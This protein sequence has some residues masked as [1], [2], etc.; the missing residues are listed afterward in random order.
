LRSTWGVADNE[1]LIGMVARFNPGKDHTNLLDAL[2]QLAI[3][4]LA[5]RCVLVGDGVSYDNASLRSFIESR[6]L[7]DQLLLLPPTL[8]I[9]EMMAALDIHVLS[10]SGEAFPNVLAEAM[11]CGTPCVSTDV[12]DAA[13]I[14]GE[15]GWIVPPRNSAALADALE[16]AVQSLPDRQRWLARQGAARQRISQNF[17]LERM[18]DSYRRLW[19][20][21]RNRSDSKSHSPTSPQSWR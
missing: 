14:V 6:R 17:S 7:R 3:R 15:T 5:I 10:S 20:E 2:A 1:P 4:G 9:A 13:H 21:T 11:A 12:G 8:N 16:N 19:S 18:C